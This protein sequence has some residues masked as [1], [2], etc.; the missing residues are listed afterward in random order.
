M[1]R[2]RTL[3]QLEN[4]K[5]A[6][7]DFETNL[8]RRCHELRKIP[9]D[10]LET[11]DLRLLIGQQ[12]GLKFLLDLAVEKLTLDILAEG[13][14]YPGDLLKSVLTIDN[15]YWKEN[16]S[17]WQAIDNLIQNNRDIIQQTDLDMNLFYK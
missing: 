10:Q 17:Q 7:H 5:W 15:S 16:K 12:I 4:S 13:D 14:Y 1:D 11:E 6:D 3:E 8:V 2:T 9:L